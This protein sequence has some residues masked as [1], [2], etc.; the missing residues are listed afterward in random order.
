[1]YCMVGDRGGGR[2][3]LLHIVLEFLFVCKH[4]GEKER[5]SPMCLKCTCWGTILIKIKENQV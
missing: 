5:A 4:L 1:M 2:V 3:Y